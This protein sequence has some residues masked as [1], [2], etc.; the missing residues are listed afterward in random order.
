MQYKVLYH[1]LS[2]EE[3]LTSDKHFLFGSGLF[4]FKQVS[5]RKTLP[6]R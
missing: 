4:Y 1:Y 6:R 2:T 5:H 3:N